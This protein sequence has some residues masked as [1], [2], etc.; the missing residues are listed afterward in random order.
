M[1][2]GCLT[3]SCPEQLVLVPD[4]VTCQQVHVVHGMVVGLLGLEVTKT[5]Q[6]LKPVKKTLETY[7][8]IDNEVIER[9]LAQLEQ[10]C[11]EILHGENNS[12]AGL[13]LETHG[14]RRGFKFSKRMGVT[15]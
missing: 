6:F 13:H 11:E 5:P 7:V 9:S 8:H 1:E 2:L 12:Q 14:G 15:L 10:G 3:F 4:M